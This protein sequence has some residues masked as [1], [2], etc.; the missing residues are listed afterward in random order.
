[1]SKELN[2]W[3]SVKAVL[4]INSLLTS[5]VFYVFPDCTEAFITAV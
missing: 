2:D 3:C 4:L 1:M 5:P